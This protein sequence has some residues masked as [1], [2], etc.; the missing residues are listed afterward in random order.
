MIL[1]VVTMAIHPQYKRPIPAEQAD[2]TQSQCPG[3]TSSRHYLDRRHVTT[4]SCPRVSVTSFHYT[5]LEM[6]TRGHERKVT[7]SSVLSHYSRKWWYSYSRYSAVIYIHSTALSL[8][9]CT[10]FHKLI[11]H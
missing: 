11:G 4:T 9:D 2:V 8:V 5:K 3:M 6:V 10:V 1:R 7:A